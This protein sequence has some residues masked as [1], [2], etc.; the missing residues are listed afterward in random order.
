MEINYSRSGVRLKRMCIALFVVKK[1]GNPT[2]ARQSL[3][4]FWG[5]RILIL[6]ARTMSSRQSFVLGSS[7]AKVIGV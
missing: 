7:I 1:S 2:S 5:A 4:S 3:E 6:A